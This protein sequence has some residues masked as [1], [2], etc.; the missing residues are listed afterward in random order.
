MVAHLV[1]VKLRPNLTAGER[2]AFAESLIAAIRDIPNV[3]GARI[4]RR[5]RHGAGYEQATPDAGDY[6]AWIEFDD[7]EGLQAYLAHPAHQALGRHFG[8]K[9]SA[10]LVYDFEV[11][12]VE[13]IEA[14]AKDS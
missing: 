14:L 11:G 13:W 3:R 4:G 12:G 9:L 6:L 1:L 7:L 5:I 10:G 2:A 8:E